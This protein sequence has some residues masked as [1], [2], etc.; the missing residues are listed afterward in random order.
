MAGALTLGHPP[1]PTLLPTQLNLILTPPHTPPISRGSCPL[2]RGGCRAEEMRHAT[3]E[4]FRP[5]LSLPP[6]FHQLASPHPNPATPHS[7][8]S[9]YS[10]PHP[11]LD[12]LLAPNHPS[13]PSL[14]P[15][16]LP[17]SPTPRSPP[18]PPPLPPPLT[19]HSPA[20]LRSVPAPPT[21]LSPPL[22]TSLHSPLRHPPYP[23]LAPPKPLPTPSRRTQAAS[24]RFP[25]GCGTHGYAQ[26]RRPPK[27]SRLIRRKWAPTSGMRL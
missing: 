3:W 20:M 10:A 13:Y 27:S 1:H 19:P 12:P 18:T 6:P 7:A 21:C 25:A 14:T 4:F 26:A 11:S 9:P 8:P 23:T 16:P 22:Y 5:L 24:L 17:P 2:V 15:P